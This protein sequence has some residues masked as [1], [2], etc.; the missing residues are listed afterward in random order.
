VHVKTS[1][2][3]CRP[4]AT[5]ENTVLEHVQSLAVDT[6]NNRWAR[7]A[8]RVQQLV[9]QFQLEPGGRRASG[10][11]VYYPDGYEAGVSSFG[12]QHVTGAFLMDSFSQF[13][14]DAKTWDYYVGRM[15]LNLWKQTGH[16][17][18]AVCAGGSALSS[19]SGS[20]LRY[21]EL[22]AELPS[23]LD[24]IIPVICGNDFYRKKKSDLCVG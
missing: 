12:G 22:L 23:G 16:V 15:L 24:V 6:R 20:G 2:G 5:K 1:I 13:H 7:R 19:P 14:V 21:S 17:Y 8:A 4:C 18:M 11:W 9:S 3:I 10:A